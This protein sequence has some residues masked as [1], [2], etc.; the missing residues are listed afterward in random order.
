MMAVTQARTRSLLTSHNAYS[1]IDRDVYVFMDD[2]R[3]MHID[4]LDYMK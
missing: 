3:L 1:E 4:R 2:K